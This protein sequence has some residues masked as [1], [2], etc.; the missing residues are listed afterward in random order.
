MAP[1]HSGLLC[2]I[3]DNVRNLPPYR[4]QDV[5][6]L[7]DLPRCRRIPAEYAPTARL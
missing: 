1:D 4:F 5:P 2:P 6:V 7:D 3:C